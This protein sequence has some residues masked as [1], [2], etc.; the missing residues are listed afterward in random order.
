MVIAAPSIK[1]GA[2]P[3]FV[4]GTLRDPDVRSAL[5][6]DRN[7][8]L[9]TSAAWMKD[10]RLYRVHGRSY[11]M[12]CAA[13]GGCVEGLLLAGLTAK[14]LHLLDAFEGEEYRR[15]PARVLSSGGVEIQAQVYRPRTGVRR[16][17]RIW[18]Y[19]QWSPRERRA[20]LARV[21]T[22]RHSGQWTD[23]GTVQS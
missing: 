6:D 9:E 22:W 11:P 23:T 4:Y 3:L 19:D 13:P 7:A 15:L 5:L 17:R 21:R 18:R 20:M 12:I 14:Q 10:H 8:N 2:T 1:N 16:D